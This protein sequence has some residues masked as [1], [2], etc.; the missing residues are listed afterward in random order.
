M[1]DIQKRVSS[2][3]L[4][5]DMLTGIGG[6]INN[7]GKSLFESIGGTSSVVSLGSNIV[8]SLLPERITSGTTDTINGVFDIAKNIPGPVGMYATLGQTAFNAIDALGAT[9]LASLKNNQDTQETIANTGGGY[10]DFM[11]DWEAASAISGK[12]AGLFTSKSSLNNKIYD[13]N[14]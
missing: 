11:K 3:K 1:A 9:K 2:L 6:G 14:R 13:A 5:T 7:I 8:N 10:G 12:N 4:S